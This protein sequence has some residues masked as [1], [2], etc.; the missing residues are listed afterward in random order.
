MFIINGVNIFPSQIETIIMKYPEIGT[1]YQINLSKKGA[2]DKLT[3][4]VELY[5][6]L[7]K[8]DFSLLENLKYKIA[9]ELNISSILIFPNIELHE[10]GSLPVSEG[11]AI[12]VID[13]R[14]KL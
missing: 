1:N 4:K 12:R 14:N 3:I 6:K 2:L 8:G 5:S 13:D 9:D 10:P 7:F 11:K